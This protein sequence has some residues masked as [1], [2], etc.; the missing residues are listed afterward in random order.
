MIISILGV[1]KSGAAY[2]PLDS[3]HPDERIRLIC[4]ESDLKYIITEN[5]TDLF[6]EYGVPYMVSFDHDL[7]D[8]HYTPPEYWDDYDKS[9]EYQD[10]Q[11]YRE[12]TGYDCAKWLVQYCM[13][14]NKDF[15]YYFVHSMNPVGADYIK[16]Y[17]NNYLKQQNESKNS[18]IK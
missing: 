1:L 11:S 5:D 9:K 10:A 12:K 16:N 6:E 8:E 15:P 17:I 4:E 7:A 13:D 14:N 2:V 3:T 18:E